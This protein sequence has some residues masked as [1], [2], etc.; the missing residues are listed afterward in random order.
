MKY[1]V[2]NPLTGQYADAQ[3]SAEAEELHKQFKM[4]FGK[5][6]FPDTITDNSAFEA[7]NSLMSEISKNLNT[8]DWLYSYTDYNITTGERLACLFITGKYWVKISNNVLS[9]LYENLRMDNPNW[10][11]GDFMYQCLDLIT[12][13]PKEF[14]K[15]E[16][17]LLCKYDLDGNKLRTYEED[18]NLMPE[19]DREKFN[20][21]K[22]K[23][24]LYWAT[25]ENGTFIGVNESETRTG[26][27]MTEND[28]LIL[29]KKRKD[30]VELNKDL[31]VVNYVSLSYEFDTD[32][33][34][35]VHETWTVY[36]T[37]AWS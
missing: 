36:D 9:E 21:F 20:N 26:D 29:E 22:Y 18:I 3:N 2:F 24:L 27:E 30:F 33:N 34:E 14:Y 23:K 7:E 6:R 35:K 31:F 12:K 10:Q 37:S 32:G 8:N 5:N 16:N 4:N 17:D 25:K 19:S 11:E 15:L 13:E 28:L 1:K